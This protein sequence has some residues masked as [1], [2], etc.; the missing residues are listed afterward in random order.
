M[1]HIAPS[2]TLT[3]TLVE[4]GKRTDGIFIIRFHL[5]RKYF[6]SQFAVV[7]QDK[8]YFHVVAMLLLILSRVEVQFVPGS[9]QHLG[10][11]VLVEH[12]LVHRQFS[13]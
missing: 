13:Q 3:K 4:P 10:N 2:Y 5:Y 12:T 6:I 7:R 11:Y 1:N 8:I 9:H